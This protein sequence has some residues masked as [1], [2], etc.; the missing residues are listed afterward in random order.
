MEDRLQDF[1]FKKSTYERPNR[2]WVCGRA[3]DG[4][5]CH[6]GPSEDGRCWFA[7]GTDCVNRRYECVPSSGKSGAACTRPRHLGGKCSQGPHPDGSCALPIP[8][9]PVRCLRSI[10]HAAAFAML[11]AALGFAAFIWS[12]PRWQRSFGAPGPLIHAHASVLADQGPLN[13]QCAYCHSN[14]SGQDAQPSKALSRIDARANQSE[15]CLSCHN[16]G[17]NDAA[18]RAH[19]L[20][21]SRSSNTRMVDVGPTTTPTRSPNGAAHTQQSSMGIGGLLTSLTTSIANPTEPADPWDGA[22]ARCHREHRG[23]DARLAAMQPTQ[24]QTCHAVAL[25]PFAQ[26][27]PRLLGRFDPHQPRLLA[28]DHAAH[29]EKYLDLDDAWNSTACVLCHTPDR[30]AANMTLNSFEATCA[31]C[32]DEDIYDDDDSDGIVFLATSSDAGSLTLDSLTPFMT[33]LLLGSRADPSGHEVEADLAALSAIARGEDNPLEPEM[34]EDIQGRLARAVRQLLDDLDN[35]E[36]LSN[37]LQRAAKTSLDAAQVDALTGRLL[38]HLPIRTAGEAWSSESAINGAEPVA[39]GNWM[40]F[41]DTR[42][43]TYRPHDHADPFMTAW[44]DLAATIVQRDTSGVRSRAAF[45]ITDLLTGPDAPGQCFKCHAPHLPEPLVEARLAGGDRTGAADRK[46]PRIVWTAA[47]RA[48]PQRQLTRFTHTP[49]LG[50][51]YGQCEQC[52]VRGIS[53]AASLQLTSSRR[54]AADGDGGFAPIELGTCAT[55]HVPQRAGNDCSLC[56]Q[57]HTTPAA[58]VLSLRGDLSR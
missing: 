18:L 47:K 17:S 49:H 13:Q 3:S 52:H 16:L 24:C 36:A 54:V 12:S 56:H 55:C 23:R 44:Y 32:H 20:A 15:R 5:A 38:E 48:E 22:C 7:G 35:R 30:R 28:F 4:T 2:R 41:D 25:E 6:A 57:Y 50:L 33:L 14:A 45:A 10:R 11:A 26:G 58:P 27:H 46:T 9:Q 21:K 29:L 51:L 39:A 37:R 42:R 34:P 31:Q 8:C 40:R 53:H 1:S 19:G 43:I